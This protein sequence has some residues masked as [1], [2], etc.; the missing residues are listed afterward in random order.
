M[1]DGGELQRY[2]HEALVVRLEQHDIGV[3]E[4]G[5]FD[6]DEQ[7]VFAR[8]WYWN[9]VQV[10]FVIARIVSSMYVSDE[11]LRAIRSTYCCASMVLEL[12]LAA[13]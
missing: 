10:K 11:V 8:F 7:F 5:V 2:L 13:D 6:L 1:Y 4:G 12:I 9:L 3:A